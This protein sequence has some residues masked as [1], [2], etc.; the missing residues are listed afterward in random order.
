MLI[1]EQTQSPSTFPITSL[2]PYLFQESQ[3]SR[4]LQISFSD[5]MPCI[6]LREPVAVSFKYAPREDVDNCFYGV[7]IGGL[8]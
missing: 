8:F 6:K 2:A 1:T 4:K 3:P 7:P 5:S